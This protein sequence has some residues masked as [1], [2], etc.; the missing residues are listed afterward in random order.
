MPG[1][2]LADVHFDVDA[3][4]RLRAIGYR[5]EEARVFKGRK[6]RNRMSDKKLLEYALERRMPILTDNRADFYRLHREMP[7]HE[8][9]VACPRYNDPV[10]KAN[11][12]HKLLRRRK[13]KNGRF[14]GE[15][16]RLRSQ[17]D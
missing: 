10:E 16:M 3:V 4:K 6:H 5:V 15:W 7:W 12:I 14:T 9:I 1:R 2:L 8:G 11:R 13:H 17:H